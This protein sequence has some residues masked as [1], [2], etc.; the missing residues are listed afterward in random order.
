MDYAM[1]YTNT[2]DRIKR[3]EVLLWACKKYYPYIELKEG[4]EEA[5]IEVDKTEGRKKYE[6]VARRKSYHLSA[7]YC[8]I[9]KEERLKI[10]KEGEK[11]FD[12]Y[13]TYVMKNESTNFMPIILNEPK[14]KIWNK[15]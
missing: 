13:V 2:G 4:S 15:G 6:R 12:L 9:P 8:N 5:Y 1:L 14:Y 11:H 10:K 3:V 7:L